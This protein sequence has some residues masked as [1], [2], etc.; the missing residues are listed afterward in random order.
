MNHYSIALAGIGN[1]INSF[2]TTRRIW[3]DALLWWPQY[4][5]GHGL[6]PYFEELFEPR[7]F[8]VRTIGPEIGYSVESCPTIQP[9]KSSDPKKITNQYGIDVPDDVKREIVDI[10]S[11]FKPADSLKRHVI[12][13][14]K[15]YHIRTWY[16]TSYATPAR[17]VIQQ[18]DSMDLKQTYVACDN[19]I[20]QKWLY[21]NN[22]S[23]LEPSQSAQ[24]AVIDLFSLSHC[25]ELKVHRYSTFGELA[26]YLGGAKAKCEIYG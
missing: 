7:D 25:E 20:V 3:P 1:R 23:L 10:V 15:G 8:V 16:D 26:F 11:L 13:R 22:Y 12:K 9:V 24:R 18:L 21:K 5:G 6:V 19:I 4:T 14:K 17:Y 2:I